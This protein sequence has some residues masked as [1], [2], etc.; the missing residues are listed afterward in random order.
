MRKKSSPVKIRSGQIEFHKLNVEQRDL[1]DI[2]HWMLTLSYGVGQLR[3]ALAWSESALL[4]LEAIQ[5]PETASAA[6]TEPDTRTNR[7][8]EPLQHEESKE[9][10]NAK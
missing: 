7:V 9:A 10:R 2:Y 8:P 5:E 1:R 6:E 3:A 4:T